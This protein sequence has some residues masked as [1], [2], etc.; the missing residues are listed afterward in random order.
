MSEAIV[1]DRAVA[2]PDSVTTTHSS[3]HS[4]AIPPPIVAQALPVNHAMTA[5]RSAAG[6]RGFVS[7]GSNSPDTVGVQRRRHD[8]G[9]H[10]GRKHVLQRLARG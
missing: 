8:H 7:Q 2:S 6:T 1:E 3:S 9:G 5:A 10:D 4:A